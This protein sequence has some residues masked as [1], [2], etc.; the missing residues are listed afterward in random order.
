MAYSP[1]V[2]FLL[3][4]TRKS[5]RLLLRDFFELENL[6]HSKRPTTDFVARSK[7]KLEELLREE[8]MRYPN[9]SIA[10]DASSLNPAKDMHF[11]I[12]PI[13]GEVNL[14]RAIPFFASVVIACE[15]KNGELLPIASAINF[16]ALGE[17]IYAERG[18][19][20]FMERSVDNASQHSLRLRVS[21]RDS[22]DGALV[23]SDF[24]SFKDRRMIGSDMYSSYLIAS[25]KADIFMANSMNDCVRWAAELIVQEAGGRIY[26]D[27]EVG[28]C[29]AKFIACNGQ[30]KFSQ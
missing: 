24:D 23:I 1:L 17:V 30:F 20:V 26:T 9:S 8:L 6:Q 10:Y 27:K 13:D 5:A 3:K 4:A 15:Y 28:G 19:G 21:A 18:K 11:I 16:P 22:I 14:G 7:A 2:N 29:A 25:G 12:T